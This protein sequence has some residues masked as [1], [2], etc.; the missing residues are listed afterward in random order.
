MMPESTWH[1]A[2]DRFPKRASLNV[3]PRTPSA[4]QM[5]KIAPTASRPR[6]VTELLKNQP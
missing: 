1:P 2:Q 3:K 5:R 4:Y 6:D